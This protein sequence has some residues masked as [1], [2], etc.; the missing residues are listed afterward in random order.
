MTFVGGTE[1][2]TKALAAR[3][4]GTERS[5]GK[6]RL[7]ETEQGIGKVRLAET[8][9]SIGKVRLAETERSIGN[10]R[11]GVAVDGLARDEAGDYV[12]RLSNGESMR[13]SQVLVTTPAAPAAHMLQSVAPSSATQLQKLRVVSTG[14]VFLGY[15]RADV[16]HPLNGFGVVIPRREQRSLNATTWMTTKFNH[17]APAEHVLIRVFFGGARTPAMMDKNDDEV[18]AIARAELRELIGLEAAPVL[19]RVYRWINAQP[20]YDVGHLERMQH[21]HQ[22]LPASIHIAG[23]PYGGVGIPDCV[24]QAQE[25]ARKIVANLHQNDA[26]RRTLAS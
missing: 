18:L 19:H 9:R 24:R 17:R 10:M 22:G 26:I 8:E 15:R 6:V 21:I 11:L 20:Q 3:L 14:V 2:L 7:A 12:L 1:T 16:A 5:I 4:I 25:A 13:A 23:S